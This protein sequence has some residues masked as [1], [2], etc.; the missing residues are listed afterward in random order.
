MKY[1]L[2]TVIAHFFI[3]A[4][5]QSFITYKDTVNRFSI[6]IPVGWKY[7]TN[8]KFPDLLLIAQRTPLNQTD[9]SRDNFNINVIKTPAKTLEKTFNDFLGYLP[10]AKDYKLINTGDT[11]FNGVKFKWLIETHKNDNSDIQMHNYDFVTLK[12]GKTF[13]LTLV[14][15]SNSFDSVKSLFDKIASS[16]NLY[17]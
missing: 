1:I 17:D 3:S 10:D 9:N 7:G 8:K 11:T 16:F 14:T 4:N 13:I 15:F 6:D 2:L 12:N 5:G